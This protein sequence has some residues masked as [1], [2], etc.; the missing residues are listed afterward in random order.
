MNIHCTRMAGYIM[1]K[2]YHVAWLWSSC[3]E[4]SGIFDWEERVRWKK[5]RSCIFRPVTRRKRTG[6]H[7]IKHMSC[8]SPLCR[9]G[10]ELS[11]MGGRESLWQH[12][13]FIVMLRLSWG[14]WLRDHQTGGVAVKRS[15]AFCAEDCRATGGQCRRVKMGCWMNPCFLRRSA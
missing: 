15:I 14:R 10:C 13:R 8:R 5:H 11:N 4:V 12:L 3:K 1:E 7:S 2:E 9:W 6:R